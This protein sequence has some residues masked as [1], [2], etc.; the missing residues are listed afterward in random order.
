MIPATPIEFVAILI[1]IGVVCHLA[2]KLEW[3]Q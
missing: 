3:W 2:D 1:A